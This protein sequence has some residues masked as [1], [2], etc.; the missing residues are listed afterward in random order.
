MTSH[1]L[2]IQLGRVE[3]KEKNPLLCSSLLNDWTVKKT[4]GF[5]RSLETVTIHFNVDR[6]CVCHPEV[7]AI[8][9]IRTFCSVLTKY[10]PVYIHAFLEWVKACLLRKTDLMGN[11]IIL[12]HNS[13]YGCRFLNFIYLTTVWLMSVYWRW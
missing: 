2:P 4:C 8:K 12:I 7:I 1:S 13:A 5:S 10:S 3:K 6:S 9:S 11:S